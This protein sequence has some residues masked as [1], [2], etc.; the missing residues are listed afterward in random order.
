MLP[1]AFNSTL[2]S[3]M[4]FP[5][6]SHKVE[7]WQGAHSAQNAATDGNVAAQPVNER[8]V[9][10]KKGKACRSKEKSGSYKS[11]KSFFASIAHL[12]FASRDHRLLSLGASLYLL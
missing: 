9:T 4:Q 12:S 5:D 10:G 8:V 6:V 7:A 1:Q 3:V 2:V 11:L